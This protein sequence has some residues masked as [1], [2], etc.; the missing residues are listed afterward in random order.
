MFIKLLA[1]ILYILF[2][3]FPVFASSLDEKTDLSQ[4][5]LEESSISK[6]VNAITSQLLNDI[7][8]SISLPRKVRIALRSFD[9]LAIPI[10]VEL[11]NSINDHLLSSLIHT[12]NGKHTFVARNGII[13][14]IK[15]LEDTGVW[16]EDGEKAFSDLMS[17]AQEIDILI[18]GDIRLE[19]KTA[20]ITYVAVSTEANV[21]SISTPIKIKL[22]SEQL[23]QTHKLFPLNQALKV[24]AKDLTSN[25]PSLLELQLGEFRNGKTRK[26]T[27]FGFYL[28]KS[29]S[30]EIQ[31]VSK[32]AIN[33]FNLPVRIL[34]FYSDIGDE[35]K[36]K[37]SSVFV[38]DGEY[39]KKENSIEL[40]VSLTNKNNAK[41]S[42]IGDVYL[43]NDIIAKLI[44]KLHDRREIGNDLIPIEELWFAPEKASI[45]LTPDANSKIVAIVPKN[46]KVYVSAK[47]KQ[48]PW[49][50]IHNNYD[51]LGYVYEKNLLSNSYSQAQ[52][53][54]E[55]REAI[56]GGDEGV[57]QLMLGDSNN[58][59]GPWARKLAKKYGLL[60]DDG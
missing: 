35:P 25:I 1:C 43:T 36:G 29:L 50:L 12:S 6:Q 42:W 54:Q 53:N 41:V 52:I 51:I 17:K 55:F 59:L 20:Y 47:L 39:L 60:P 45:H 4:V 19:K 57:I 26:L 48:S 14:I 44:L 10:S 56:K 34:E 9:P 21:A 23:N 46:E 7:D 18:K 49:L 13:T 28:Q 24:A 30:A 31:Q 5:K 32:D 38:L 11:A 16:G 2:S 58:N 33:G 8:K 15:D 22:T 3:I 37:N 40:S 27:S